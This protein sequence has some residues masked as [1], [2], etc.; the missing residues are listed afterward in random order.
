MLVQ[1][2]VKDSQFTT[3]VLIELKTACRLEGKDVK[4]ALRKRVLRRPS[5]EISFEK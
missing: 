3:F 2:S 4:Q 5:P 1:Y